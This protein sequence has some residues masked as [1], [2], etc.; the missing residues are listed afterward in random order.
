MS[1]RSSKE[2]RHVLANLGENLSEEECMEMINEIDQDGDG[3][4]SFPGMLLF[5]RT[6]IISQMQR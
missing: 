5:N 3:Q 4:V 1:R 2:L 6:T